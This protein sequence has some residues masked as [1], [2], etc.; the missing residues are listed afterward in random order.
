MQVPGDLVPALKRRQEVASKFNR[1]IQ[2][3]VAVVGASI[4][5][6]DACYVV[7]DDIKY[8]FDSIVKAFDICFKAIHS[9]NTEYS[10][11]VKGAWLFVQQALYR[12]S[13]RYDTK[14][15]AV[16]ALVKSFQAL[17]STFKAV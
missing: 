8:R 11:E 3:F 14:N 10:Y 12:I 9:L 16:A 7:V 13:T 6:Y 5:K 17:C 4:E 2:P 15:S 1:R